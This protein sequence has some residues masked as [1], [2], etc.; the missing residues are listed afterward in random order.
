MSPDS[1]KDNPRRLFSMIFA[2]PE[3][4][5]KLM[6]LEE[7][8]EIQG[9]HVDTNLVESPQQQET[10]LILACQNNCLV[11]AEYLLDRGAD[12]NLSVRYQAPL[13]HSQTIEMA[14]LLLSRGGKVSK[15]DLKHQ[16]SELRV[17]CQHHLNDNEGLKKFNNKLP[18]VDLLMNHYQKKHPRQHAKEFQKHFH[19]LSAYIDCNPSI[20]DLFDKY[21]TGIGSHPEYKS[22]QI[23]VKLIN[24]L[25]EP[26]HIKKI[27]HRYQSRIQHQD[28]LDGERDLD[29][30]FNLEF[31]FGRIANDD[32]KIIQETL[33][34]FKG[35]LLNRELEATLLKANSSSPD[36]KS[37][38]M[39]RF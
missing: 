29:I 9:L 5:E 32:Y 24:S 2:A 28:Y 13:M 34:Q 33:L 6:L 27:L 36:K 4:A 15:L 38:T 23:W 11:T 20:L 17:I 26:E 30:H 21:N 39:G 25:S 7:I 18:L 37:L 14:E 10:P 12:P 19:E 35:S 16:L 31:K 1:L 3:K 22:S 8:V